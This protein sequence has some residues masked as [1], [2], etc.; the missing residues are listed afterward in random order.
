MLKQKV[1]KGILACYRVLTHILPLHKK[2]VVFQSSLGRNASGN[3]RAVYDKMVELGLDKRYRCYYILDKPEKYRGKLDGRVR[4]LRNARLRYYFVMAM[5]GI[6]ISDTRFQNYIVKRRG[7]I[8]IQ[9]WHGTPLKKLALDLDSLHMAGEE[10]LEQYREA[11]RQN[12][13]TWDYLLSQNPYSTE[14]FRRAFDYH[15]RILEIG[16]PRNDR[17]F[18]NLTE[19]ELNEIKGSLGLPADKKVLLYAPTWRD[20][21]YYDKSAYRFQ[22]QMDFEKMRQAFGGEYVL[23]A[24]LHYMMRESEAWEPCPGF[25]YP[26]G[27]DTDIAVLYQLAELLI[28]DY[29][30]VMFDFSL[31]GKPMVF[32]TYDIDSYRDTLRG[33]YFDFE[34][35]APGPLV[36]TTDAL[37]QAVKDALNGAKAEGYQ[38]FCEKYNPYD[39]G[40]ASRGVIDVF[41]NTK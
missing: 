36:K 16:Y 25:V 17:L 6:W 10:T 21:A 28:T 32:F 33:F 4:L 11:F 27:E 24:K 19:E 12:S 41:Y 22:T 35:E 38:R 29:S 14:V 37:I 13:A 30:S 20:D 31:T 15:G 34:K 40:N 2:I 18:E 8:Y 9:T 26:M 3:P 1:K 39:D 5:A 7:V 23:V